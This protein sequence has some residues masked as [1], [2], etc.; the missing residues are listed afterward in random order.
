MSWQNTA[1]VRRS[2]SHEEVKALVGDLFALTL[3]CG[4][5]KATVDDATTG[6]VHGS[7]SLVVHHEESLVDS[8]V[9]KN[10]SDGWLVGHLVVQSLNSLLELLDFELENLLALGITN[11]VAVDDQV[12]GELA[13]VV[14]CEALQGFLE[15]FLQFVL[16]HF[17]ALLLNDVVRVVL[18]HVLVD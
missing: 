5:R 12:C 11:T 4:L 15:A 2:W 17:F 9:N 14:L 18:R 10:N 1:L 13:L 16:H 6:W 7:A 8:F 3:R